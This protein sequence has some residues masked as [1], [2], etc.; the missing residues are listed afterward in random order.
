MHNSTHEFY[1][2]V[3]VLKSSFL[4]SY[5]PHNEGLAW[6]NVWPYFL[7]RNVYFG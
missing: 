2:T 6:V 5:L 1:R 3:M 7:E 4:L